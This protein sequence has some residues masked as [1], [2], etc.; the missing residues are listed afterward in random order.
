MEPASQRAAAVASATVAILVGSKMLDAKSLMIISRKETK[1]QT[2]NLLARSS[3]QVSGLMAATVMVL[4]LAVCGCGP[5]E[6]A[7]FD[8]PDVD[9]ATSNV[10]AGDVQQFESE[11]ATYNVG[12]VFPELVGEDLYGKSLSLADYRGKVILLDFFG[13]W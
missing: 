4:M 13:D 3:C 11:N 10:V 9:A 7:K 5:T 12:D 8:Q 1:M 2:S 6:T